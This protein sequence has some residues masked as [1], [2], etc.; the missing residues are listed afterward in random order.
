MTFRQ[1]FSYNGET[2]QS[3]GYAQELLGWKETDYD[4]ESWPVWDAS[5]APSA[6]TGAKNTRVGT[7]KLSSRN[8]PFLGC[9]HSEDMFADFLYFIP[10]VRS[11]LNTTCKALPSG[12][13]T[14]T[15]NILP[16]TDDKWFS[17]WK[18]HCSWIS[19]CRDWHFVAGDSWNPAWSSQ[20]C[21][22]PSRPD[23]LVS[24]PGMPPLRCAES[25]DHPEGLLMSYK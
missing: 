5:H 21:F 9:V 3:K 6:G 22:D 8:K 20:L 16:C 24:L 12:N 2:P 25:C 4:H 19:K 7:N 17:Y 18:P 11:T 15:W 13:Q 10:L 14:W 23:P 1:F